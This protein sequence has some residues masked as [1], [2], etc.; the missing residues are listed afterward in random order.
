MEV[1]LALI[2]AIIMLVPPLLVLVHD[3]IKYR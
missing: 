1:F 3:L 2:P